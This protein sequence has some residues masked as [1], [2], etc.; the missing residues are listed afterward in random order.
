[1]NVLPLRL[2]GDAIVALVT[3]AKAM[4]V[5]Q[6]GLNWTIVQRTFWSTR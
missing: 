3:M 4:M 2:L 6:T 5:R 1:M